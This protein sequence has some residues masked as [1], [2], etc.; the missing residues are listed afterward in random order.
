MYQ[1]ILDEEMPTNFEKKTDL[2]ITFNDSTH[3]L[4]AVFVLEVGYI[5]SINA[6]LSRTRQ[7]NCDV[8]SGSF[9]QALVG[10][11]VLTTLPIDLR[12]WHLQLFGLI[13]Q[14]FQKALNKCFT[15]IGIRRCDQTFH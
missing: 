15:L 3:L 4:L 12:L 6:D 9:A 11:Y 7:S 1:H 8:G 5:L 2:N 14:R 13:H 10:G